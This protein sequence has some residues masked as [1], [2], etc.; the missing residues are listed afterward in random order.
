MGFKKEYFGFPVPL[1]YITPNLQFYP[2]VFP[3]EFIVIT[4]NYNNINNEVTLTT[5]DHICFIQTLMSYLNR[6]YIIVNNSFLIDLTRNDYQFKIDEETNKIH[7]THY[8]PINNIIY[9]CE[10]YF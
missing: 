7:I 4:N 3:Q 10:K 6:D 5:K 8:K 1:H 9:V 2:L